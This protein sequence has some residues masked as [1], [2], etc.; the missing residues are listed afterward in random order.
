MYIC[1]IY[2]YIFKGLHV[3]KKTH[4]QFQTVKFQ[5]KITTKYMF[6]F[7]FH[8]LFQR[9]KMLMSHNFNIPKF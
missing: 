8:K 9:F 4:T 2:I 5:K 6:V 1:T 7:Y 3:H